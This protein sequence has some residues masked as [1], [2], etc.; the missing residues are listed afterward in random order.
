MID[1]KKAGKL[2]SHTR[3][4]RS[5]RRTGEHLTDEE[6]KQ[7]Q[8]IFLDAFS[9]SANVRASCLKAGISRTTIYEWAEHDDEF[10][11]LYK[12][13]ELDANDLIRQELYRRAVTG[14]DKP[15]VSVGRVVTMK[16]KNG[17]EHVVKDRVYSDMLLSLLAKARLP[18]FREKSSTVGSGSLDDAEFE[19]DLG[20]V[21]PVE[22]DD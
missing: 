13:A 2:T 18:E 12:Q 20:G 17:K 1:D 4:R 15:L 5:I 10:S 3:T 22:D 8:E 6:R 19:I 14:Y 21:A 11:I 7:T 16:D 9:V